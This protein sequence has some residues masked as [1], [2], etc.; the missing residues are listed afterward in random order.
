[1]QALANVHEIAHEDNLQKE[2]LE[3][4]IQNA[5]ILMNIQSYEKPI[6]NI[7]W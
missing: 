7:T 3:K 5:V 1:M 4:Q 6:S 2:N